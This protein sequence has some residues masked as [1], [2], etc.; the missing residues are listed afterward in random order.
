MEGATSATAYFDIQN[1]NSNEEYVQLPVIG[2]VYH[3]AENDVFIGKLDNYNQIESYY[4]EFSFTENYELGE[5]TYTVGYPNSSLY[6]QIN[7]GTLLEEYK[8]ILGKINNSYY[9]LSDS[10]I[11]P[12]SSGGILI[13]NNFEII[14]IT[15]MGLYADSNKTIYLAGGSIPTSLFLEALKNLNEDDLKLLTEIY[16]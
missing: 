4:H 2:G 8:D 7:Q 3:S 16:Y 9:L 1:T 6:M 12:G 13:N 10:Y 11:A 5:T 14:G 15:T